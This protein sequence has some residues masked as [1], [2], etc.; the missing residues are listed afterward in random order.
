MDSLY[1]AAI[2][3]EECDE[4]YF[5]HFSYGQ[6]TQDKERQ[7]F[8]AIAEHYRAIQARIVDY[9]WLAEIGGSAL[10]DDSIMI[11]E[12]GGGIPN[13]YVPF[14]NAT[15]LCAA[16]AWAEVIK[17]SRIYIGAVQEDSSGYPDC[18][19]VFFEAMTEVITQGT[20]AANISI[21]TPVLHMSKQMIVEDGLKRRVPFEL[22]W[23][24]YTGQEKACG[25]CPSCILRLKA[26]HRA[27]IKDPI[28][29][30]EY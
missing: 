17:A 26:F 16:V 27:G 9:Q 19:E 15:M 28:T 22:S 1:T 3:R 23:S 30:Q 7:C 5:L 21:H 13:T 25:R 4:L 10:T 6:R 12:M 18:R 20:V 29:Y 24:C 11:K 8:M 2:A 14:R